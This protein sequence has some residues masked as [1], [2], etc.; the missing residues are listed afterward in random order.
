MRT[1]IFIG[2]A[3]VAGLSQS[4]MAQDYV[5]PAYEY[6][7]PD[8]YVYETPTSQRYYDGD[9]YVRVCHED[10]RDRRDNDGWSD[11]R[12]WPQPDYTTTTDRYG[13]Q[14]SDGYRGGYR[15]E[16]GY[17]YGYPAGWADQRY[18]YGYGYGDGYSGGYSG[19]YSA[20]Y[21][22]GYVT[23]QSGGVTVIVEHER[24]E[25]YVPVIREEIIEE[26]YE[27]TEYD[28]VRERVVEEVP[29]RYQP[30]RPKYIKS[31]K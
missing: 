12:D 30:R 31:V 13:Y 16:G 14:Y 1:T 9:D 6:S 8:A 25:R 29:V 3:A 28:T 23:T 4:A 22:G 21:G 7:A 19:G 26:T 20:A 11:C 5:G 27:T 24:G 2:M 15:G 17:A 10:P 18:G